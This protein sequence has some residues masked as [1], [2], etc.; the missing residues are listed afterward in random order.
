MWWRLGGCWLPPRVSEAPAGAQ[1]ARFPHDGPAGGCLP[2]LPIYRAH[3]PARRSHSLNDAQAKTLF[4]S[5][6]FIGLVAR[7]RSAFN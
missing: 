6:A 2:F 3:I 4:Q 5:L 7:H 1:G